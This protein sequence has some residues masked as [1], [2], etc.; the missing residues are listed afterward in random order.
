MRVI[1]RIV[2]DRDSRTITAFD[3]AGVGRAWG[4]KMEYTNREIGLPQ[5]IWDYGIACELVKGLSPDERIPPY[6]MIHYGGGRDYFGD[7]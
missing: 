4:N 6:N 1:G 3:M 2:V 5:P 7:R